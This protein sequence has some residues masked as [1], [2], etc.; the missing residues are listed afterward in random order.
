MFLE[1]IK[2]LHIIEKATIF[3]QK[4]YL[5][6]FGESYG[7]KVDRICL[8]SVMIWSTSYGGNHA[9]FRTNHRRVNTL[10]RVGKRTYMTAIQLTISVVKLQRCLSLGK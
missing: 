6:S 7:Q 10:Y 4:T 2:A 1:C 5:D 8:A 9:R 3:S